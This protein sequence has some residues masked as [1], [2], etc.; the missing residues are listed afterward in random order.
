MFLDCPVS[1]LKGSYISNDG[2]AQFIK[3]DKFTAT[4]L[5]LDDEGNEKFEG[6]MFNSKSEIA[7]F[8]RSEIEMS[9]GESKIY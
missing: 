6:F 2:S 3:G 7:Q 8:S 4:K 1:Y 5:L 9:K